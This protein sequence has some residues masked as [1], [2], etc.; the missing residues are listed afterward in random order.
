MFAKKLN[1]NKKETTL[2]CIKDQQVHQFIGPETLF[3]SIHYL[4][5][6]VLSPVFEISP[7]QVLSSSPRIFHRDERQDSSR[8]SHP[9][10]LYI[11][12]RPGSRTEKLRAKPQQSFQLSLKTA[13]QP[14]PSVRL[15]QH[16]DG[17]KQSAP[18][19]SVHHPT[20][21]KNSQIQDQFNINFKISKSLF[22]CTL[23]YIHVLN[24]INLIYFNLSLSTPI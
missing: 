21:Q 13:Q 12:P 15:N 11:Q 2:T 10:Q 8:S 4:Q 16:Q 23:P 7:L 3:L 14:S 9:S 22:Y 5:I 17:P 6:K 19:H 24:P 18:N 1:F 20:L